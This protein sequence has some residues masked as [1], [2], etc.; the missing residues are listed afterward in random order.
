V[1]HDHRR[2]RA[3]SNQED[4]C[5]AQARDLSAPR[6]PAGRRGDR[7][8]CRVGV[9]P[10]NVSGGRGHLEWRFVGELRR[11]G[12]NGIGERGDC[13]VGF[14]LECRPH[15]VLID[16]SVPERSGAVARCVE[17]A[18]EGERNRDGQWIGRGLSL[19]PADG[20]LELAAPSGGVCQCVESPKVLLMPFETFRI[21]PALELGRVAE[22]HAAQHGARVRGDCLF[23]SSGGDR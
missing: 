2:N 7:H 4:A 6:R 12:R 1:R 3:G 22:V 10:R 16:A 8:C 23:P 21:D 19:S 18:Q 20:F 14:H 9:G 13:G 17:R 11:V 15:D 5:A